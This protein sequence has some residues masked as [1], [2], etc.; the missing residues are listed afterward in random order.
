MSF[1]IGK[2][3]ANLKEI[4]QRLGVKIIIDKRNSA[5]EY[6]IVQIIGKNKADLEEARREVDIDEEVL[7]L[8]EEYA[9]Y[10]CGEGDKA[11]LSLRDKCYLYQLQRFTGKDGRQFLSAIG[12]LDSRDDL[13]AALKTILGFYDTYQ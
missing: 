3:G 9:Y 6:S 1:V 12:H 13:K 10:V 8:D 5:G 11:L 4:E 7:P 2:N